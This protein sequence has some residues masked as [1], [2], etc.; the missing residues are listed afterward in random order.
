MNTKANNTDFGDAAD[1]LGQI[2][3]VYAVYADGCL[4][5]RTRVFSE[6]LTE[7]RKWALQL[8]AALPNMG[9]VVEIKV[10]L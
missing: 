5:L 2:N 6:A 10:L 3:C 9:T 4:M 1:Y 7:F 8:N